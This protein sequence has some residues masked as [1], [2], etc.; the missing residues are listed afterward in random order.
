[1]KLLIGCLIIFLANCFHVMGMGVESEGENDSLVFV[2]LCHARNE[3]DYQL[4]KRS[5][6]SVRQFYDTTKIVIIDDNSA[7]DI[8]ND[9]FF[10]VTIIKS[11]FPGAGELLPYYYFLKYKWADKMIFLHDSM[12]LI[13]KFSNLELNCSIRFHWYF[14]KNFW[15]SDWWIHGF[16]WRI[17]GLLSYLNNADE[18]I[19]YHLNKYSK[20]SGCF[21]VASTINWS[22]L[23]NLEDKYS[24]MTLVDKIKSREDRM[25]LERVF[26][27]LVF[28]EGYVTNNDNCSN[29][30][31][32]HD[33][34]SHWT[35]F[36]DDFLNSLKLTYPGAIIKTWHLR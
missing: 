23:Q 34:P 8:S 20:L 29:F 14:D 3:D 2:I 27:L 26:A 5:Y 31:S 15:Y 17:N 9:V 33:F 7:V 22:V 4:L 10:D 35:S 32:I 11:E 18:L 13:R 25:S 1:M 6:D 16:D 28:K 21:G 30:G 36:S 19:N 12:F 24:L